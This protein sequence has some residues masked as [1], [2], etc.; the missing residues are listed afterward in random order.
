MLPTSTI[1]MFFAFSTRYG[2]EMLTDLFGCVGCGLEGDSFVAVSE[3]L[4]LYSDPAQ[5]MLIDDATRDMI[6]HRDLDD[7]IQVGSSSGDR[8]GNRITST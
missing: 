2:M 8:E 7:D 3:L 6:D 4:Q 1:I 5:T